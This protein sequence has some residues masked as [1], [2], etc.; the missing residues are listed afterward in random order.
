MPERQSTQRIFQALG[1]V[2]SI[3]LFERDTTDVL[4]EIRAMI[5]DA[6][7]CWSIFRE[8]SEISAVNRTAGVGSVSV[9]GDTFD[10]LTQAARYHELSGGAFDITLAKVTQLWKEALRSGKLPND[11]EIRALRSGAHGRINLDPG[12][13]LV[14]L[15]SG[16][17]AIDLGAIAKGYLADKIGK[18]LHERGVTNALMNLGGTILSIGELREIGIQ[19]PYMASGTRL[20]SLRVENRAVVTSGI[21]EQIAFIGGRIV[22]HLIDPRT[23]YPARS[24]IRSILLVGDCAAELDAFA[25]AVVVLGLENGMKLIQKRG[26]DAVIVLNQGEILITPNLQGAIR[27]KSDSA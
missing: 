17:Q 19:N 22:H 11:R 26:L 5:L 4:D 25:T 10:V 23:G 18:L 15:P 8:E 24:E 9:S 13:N 6:D 20:G 2:H 1:T 21:N 7:A 27:L 16:N 12:A 3:T 14:S